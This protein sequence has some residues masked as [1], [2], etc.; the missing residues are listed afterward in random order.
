MNMLSRVLRN[1]RPYIRNPIYSAK[2][3][4]FL[5]VELTPMT[6]VYSEERIFLSDIELKHSCMGIFHGYIG[7][8]G[9]SR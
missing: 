1:T 9:E 2:T 7:A 6:V 3:V 4:R 8:I 5:T